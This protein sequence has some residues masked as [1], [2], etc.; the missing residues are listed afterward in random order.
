MREEYGRPFD[1]ANHGTWTNDLYMHMSNHRQT[2]KRGRARAHAEARQD[3]SGHC[4]PL[5]ASTTEYQ[6]NNVYLKLSWDPDH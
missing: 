5:I 2:D 6:L 3:G 4:R 1:D